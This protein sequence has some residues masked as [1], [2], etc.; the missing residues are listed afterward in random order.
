M[1]VIKCLSEWVCWINEAV[2][3][4]KLHSSKEQMMI[5]QNGKDFF[6]T[7]WCF[8]CHLVLGTNSNY[9]RIWKLKH[10]TSLITCETCALGPLSAVTAEKTKIQGRSTSTALIHT[11]TRANTWR[12]TNKLSKLFH[13]KEEKIQILHLLHKCSQKHLLKCSSSEHKLYHTDKIWTLSLCRAGGGG[14]VVLG[15]GGFFT[16]SSQQ[17]P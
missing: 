11:Q 8:Q 15:L 16:I 2:W 9:E 4:I 5:F 6:R 3:W 10:K 12:R 14:W 7:F 1:H 17:F 13:K